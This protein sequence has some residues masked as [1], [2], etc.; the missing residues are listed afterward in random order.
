MCHFTHR[1]QAG[2]ETITAFPTPSPIFP[3]KY[4]RPKLYVLYQL[5]LNCMHINLKS[6]K[7][8]VQSF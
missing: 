1:S 5:Y 2:D 4:I 8:Q 7:I 3:L 6:R